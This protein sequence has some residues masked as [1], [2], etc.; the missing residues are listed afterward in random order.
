[1]LQATS[2]SVELGL[3]LT[4]DSKTSYEDGGEGRD[5]AESNI[6]KRMN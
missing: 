1:M 5:H 3:R 6:A 4:M 2:I